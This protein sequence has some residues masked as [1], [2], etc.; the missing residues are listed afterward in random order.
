[1]ALVEARGHD[2]FSAAA[3]DD[4]HAI[5]RLLANRR[6]AIDEVD[7]DGLTPLMVAARFGGSEA[8]R[9]LVEAGAAVGPTVRAGSRLGKLDV[10][11]WTALHFAADGQHRA[12]FHW[13]VA[14]GAEDH[15][16]GD[17]RR[18]AA[19]ARFALS[20]KALAERDG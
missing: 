2:L 11:G 9:V 17:G 5:T 18:A 6:D 7:A 16:A 13:L 19:R 10:S 15:V 14:R 20:D 1:A 8:A 12:L 4:A 3:L